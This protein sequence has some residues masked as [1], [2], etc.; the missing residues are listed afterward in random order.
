MVADYFA[1]IFELAT[2]VIGV[3]SNELLLEPVEILAPEGDTPGILSQCNLIPIIPINIHLTSWGY[4]IYL[5][6]S[7]TTNPIAQTRMYGWMD[8]TPQTSTTMPDNIVIRI[9][10]IILGSSSTWNISTGSWTIGCCLWNHRGLGFGSLC[11]GLCSF[12]CLMLGFA[13]L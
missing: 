10:L 1:G 7:S 13:L 4:W 5:W 8:N 12:W 3:G 9:I 2:Q 11:V 6:A